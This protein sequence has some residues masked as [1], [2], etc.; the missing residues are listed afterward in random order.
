MCDTETSFSKAIKDQKVINA[1]QTDVDRLTETYQRGKELYI[2]Q[3][4]YACHR[5]SGF[6]RGGVGPELTY[7][8]KITHG[9]L[10]IPSFGL[11]ETFQ[12]L[13]CLILGWIIKS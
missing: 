2:E 9:I 10:N 5:I 8:G 1:I 3:A 6:S 11:K 4:C 7:I 13:Q 12:H